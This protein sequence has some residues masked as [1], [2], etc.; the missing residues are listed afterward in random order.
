MW[1]RRGRGPRWS[2]G[3]VA[4]LAAVALLSLAAC[5]L[6]EAPVAYAVPG[7]RLSAADVDGD[8]DVDLISGGGDTFATLLNDG[9]GSFT[10]VPND[11]HADFTK[12]VVLDVD[13]D[14]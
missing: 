6:G 10:T 7:A 8:G 11:E 12:M 2:S 3:G 4:G 9:A 14:G 13:L 5:D 1:A